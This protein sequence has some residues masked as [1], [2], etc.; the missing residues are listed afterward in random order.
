MR[1]K[2][3]EYYQYLGWQLFKRRG[4]EF[5]DYHR[6]QLRELGHPLSRTRLGV[7]ACQYVADHLLRPKQ[8]AERLLGRWRPESTGP[9]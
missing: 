1:E 4:R 8:T 9:R 2:L 6:G 5:W 7:H 3:R